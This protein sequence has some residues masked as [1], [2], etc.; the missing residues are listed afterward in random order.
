MSF[1]TDHYGHSAL[2]DARGTLALRPFM[3][4]FEPA[5]P[6]FEQRV[7]ESFARQQLMHTL[8]ATLGLVA[9]GLVETNC[10]TVSNSRNSTASCTR[11]SSPPCLIVPAV[12]L[13]SP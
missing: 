8:G 4:K 10:L 13:L 5:E 7:R 1:Q 2:L 6:D 11:A 3:M 12:T 9:P